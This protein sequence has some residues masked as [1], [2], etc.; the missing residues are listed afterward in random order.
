VLAAVLAPPAGAASPR[1]HSAAATQVRHELRG[2]AQHG[3]VLGSPAAPVK[4]VEYA[5]LV[6]AACPAIHGSVVPRVIARWVRTGVASLE[7]RSI[8]RGARSHDLARSAHGASP[9]SRGWDFIQLSYLR[10]AQ[11][12]PARVAAE[13][14]L[15]AARWRRDR[16]RQAFEIE[17]RAAVSVA[18]VARFGGD[19]VFLVRAYPSRPFVVLT[20]PRSVDQFAGAIAKARRRGTG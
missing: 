14:G 13:L 10:R 15:D 18:G 4:I 2:I 19:P 11:E 12:P 7:F 20:E 17:I 6:C 5:D 1:P 8:A 3:L 16:G 9:Q